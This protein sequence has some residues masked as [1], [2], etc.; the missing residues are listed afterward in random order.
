MAI[1]THCDQVLYTGDFALFHLCERLNVMRL[2][3][4]SAKFAVSLLK[5]KAAYSAPKISEP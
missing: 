3:K 5:I 2:N 4:P 1:G